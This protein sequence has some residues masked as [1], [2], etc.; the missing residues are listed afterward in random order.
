MANRW[1][2]GLIRK[3]P[4]TP[5]SSSAPGVWTLAE[6]AYWR[7]QGLWPLP[8]VIADILIVAG[9]GGGERGSGARGWEDRSYGGGDRGGDSFGAGRT[10]RRRSSGGGD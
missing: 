8:P 3:T 9:G 6:V 1:P 4:V 10:R 2:G 5:N 7:K